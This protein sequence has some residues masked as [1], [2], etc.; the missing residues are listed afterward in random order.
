MNTNKRTCL[1]CRYKQKGD[2]VCAK[3]GVSLSIIDTLYNCPLH[4]F[5]KNTI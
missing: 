2:L 1:N 5:K 4:Q 3:K